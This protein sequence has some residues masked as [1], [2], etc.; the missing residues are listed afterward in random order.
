M[1]TLL[2]ADNA[3]QNLYGAVVIPE[4]ATIALVALALVPLM[5]CRRLRGRICA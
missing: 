4:P 2:Q 3:G 5:A 1:L